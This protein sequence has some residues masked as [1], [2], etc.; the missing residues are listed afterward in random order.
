REH[1]A[2]TGLEH[3]DDLPDRLLDVGDVV[4][5]RVADDEVEG[6]VVVRDGLGVGDPA[7]DAEAELLGIPL[8]GLDHPG[9]D[10][11]DVSLV[12]NARLL[13]V[14]QEEAGAAAELEGLRVRPAV[15]ARDGG[16]PVTR[17]LGAA[18]VEGDRP[19]VVVVL[20]LP[21]V[22]NGVRLL[23]VVPDGVVV[24]VRHQRPLNSGV[25]LPRNAAKPAVLSSVANV[26]AQWTRSSSSA[27]SRSTSR[28]LSIASLAAA[29]AC[30]GPFANCLAQP[31]ASV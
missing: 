24:E 2:P 1:E 25:V 21:V 16:E 22:E 19:L 31:S 30:R 26:A 4:E 6:V 23:R 3:P 20:G 12:E 10:V 14:E 18:F 5:H 7:L 28:P 11:G 8:R 17:V 15:R 9:A 27:V 29:I 13:Q